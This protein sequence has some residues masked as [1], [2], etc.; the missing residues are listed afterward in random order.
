MSEL[1]ACLRQAGS[2]PYSL[3]Q[4]LPRFGQS[5]SL[6]L[7]TMFICDGVHFH[8]TLHPL[9]C[10]MSTPSRHPCTYPRLLVS[11]SRQCSQRFLCVYVPVHRVN[12]TFVFREGNDT[13]L[14][15]VNFAIF[16]VWAIAI[17]PCSFPEVTKSSGV[18]LL[19]QPC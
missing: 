2:C 13:L 18:L 6:V 10:K 3:G 14:Q 11:S 17:F 9:L 19:G 5:V 4:N 16:N 8:F 12:L 7:P 1:E 15:G